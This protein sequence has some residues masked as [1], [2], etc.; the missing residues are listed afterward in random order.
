MNVR[1]P[2][3][4]SR[5]LA[6]AAAFGSV[7]ISGAL[8]VLVLVA[9]PFAL[10]ASLFGHRPL[11]SRRAAATIVLLVIAIGF[12]VAVFLGGLD[13]VVAAVS[14]ATLVTAHRM[15]GEPSPQTSRQVLLAALLLVSGGAALTGDVL[16]AVFL[17]AFFFTASWSLAWL[18][19]AQDLTVIEGDERGAVNRQLAL[20]TAFTLVLGLAFFVFFPRLSWNLA[21][22]R[23]S[24]G[25]GGVTGLSDTVRLGGGGDIKTSARVAFRAALMPDPRVE[26]LGAYWVGRRFDTFDGTQW[27]SSGKPRTAIEG[28]IMV[29]RGGGSRN[30]ISQEIEVTSAYGSRTLVALETPSFYGRTRGLSVSGSQLMPLIHVPGDQVY[31]A[32]ESTGLLYTAESVRTEG[33]DL[34]EPSDAMRRLPRVD[35]RIDAL[36]AELAGTATEPRAIARALERQLKNRYEYT[37]ELPG[38]VADP[39]AD[40]L[41]VRRAGHCE[42]F[43]TA[44][45]VMLRLKGVPSRIVT[46]FFGG[47]QAGDRYVVRAG[48]AHAWVEAWLDGAWYRLDAT[49]DEGR[50]ASSSSWKAA[51][52]A[53]WERLES[54]WRLRVIDYSFQT[55]LSFARQLVRPPANAADEAQRP[56]GASS[57]WVTWLALGLAALGA[58]VLVRR[59]RARPSPHPAAS[60]LTE[61]EDRL[62]VA[63]VPG[64]GERP[65]EEL[66]RTMRPDHPLAL[67]TAH[68]TRRY[69]EARFGDIPL[70]ADERRALL[71]ALESPRR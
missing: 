23:G 21:S 25:L 68:A 48:D 26:Q 28:A 67:P 49:P 4:L 41:F 17:I 14:F 3:L 32:L 56:T 39:L 60:F 33:V 34:T 19:L 37:L 30:R 31:A 52:T 9:F 70:R 12:A 35:A 24:P 57:R 50:A 47:E 20:G 66:S 69:L 45:A 5:D 63:R 11:A 51:L 54:W 71:A 1:P 62:K 55:Q 38:D 16:Y 42:D 53:A 6:A 7:A 27:T 44:L 59:A 8:P 43:A 46:G 64:V 10:I 40:F 36:A 29:L 61:I 18:V 65:L 22:R 15:L 2:G 13:L 58:I